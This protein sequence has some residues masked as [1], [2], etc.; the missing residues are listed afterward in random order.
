M[1]SLII[2]NTCAQIVGSLLIEMTAA[3]R[4]REERMTKEEL[5]LQV[6]ILRQKKKDMKLVLKATIN[7]LQLNGE[8]NES[9]DGEPDFY[10]NKGWIEACEWM[11]KK[12]NK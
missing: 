8:E 12:I 2:A 9:W 7:D 11:L 10:I 4:V 3:T 6:K 5:E 1:S